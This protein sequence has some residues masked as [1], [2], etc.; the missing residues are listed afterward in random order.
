[1]PVSEIVDLNQVVNDYFETLEFERL[2]AY[3]PQVSIQAEL[4]EEAPYVKGSPVHLGKTLMNL[5]SNAAEALP[6]QGDVTVRTGFCYLD[7]PVRGYDKVE[8]GNYTVL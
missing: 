7:R 3:H 5:V 8:A 1:M 6:E 2:K 4:S